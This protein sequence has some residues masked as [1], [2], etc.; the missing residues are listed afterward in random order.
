MFKI[1]NNLDL[2]NFRGKMFPNSW[3][4]NS[5]SISYLKLLHVITLFPL[6]RSIFF[7]IINIHVEVA[8][9]EYS[10]WNSLS[11]HIDCDCCH[12]DYTCW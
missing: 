12:L 2:S 7:R 8:S 1:N 3:K 10:L 9:L 11:D 4:L 6:Y 5:L